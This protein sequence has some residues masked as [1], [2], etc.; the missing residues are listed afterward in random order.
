MTGVGRVPGGV[1]RVT[2]LGLGACR[3]CCD[4][5]LR[6]GIDV[7]RPF[8]NG[9]REV[10]GDETALPAQS[11]AQGREDDGLDLGLRPT[12]APSGECA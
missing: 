8:G 9:A 12:S 1:T 11:A 10:C 3:H 7:G 4:N 2:L 6:G 5:L